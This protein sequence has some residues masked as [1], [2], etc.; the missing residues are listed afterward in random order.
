ME[1]GWAGA[2][3]LSLPINGLGIKQ[4]PLVWSLCGGNSHTLNVLLV[5][6][7]FVAL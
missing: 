5:F 2:L 3:S 7:H 1:N 6:F 4:T